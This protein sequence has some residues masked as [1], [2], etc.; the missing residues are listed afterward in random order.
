MFKLSSPFLPTGDQPQAI[1][2]LVKNLMSGARHQ[3][4]LGV[5]GSGKTFTMANVIAQTQRPTLV[6]SPNK[7]L[8][9]QLWQE[10]RE[11]FPENPV[12]Y[13][14]SYYDY[15]QP[16]AYLPAT[17]TY[18]EKDAKINDFIDRLRHATTQ[19]ALSRKDFI[20]VASVS[21]IYGIGNP[22]EYRKMSL[23]LR[24][25]ET[26]KRSILLRRLAMLQYERLQPTEAPRQGTYRVNGD[27]MMLLTPDGETSMTIELLGD[28]V[29]RLSARKVYRPGAHP[30][31][32]QSVR[33]FPAKHFVAPE[34]SLA[35]AI[36]NIEA[37]LEGRLAALKKEGKIF[38]AARLQERTRFDLTMLR[39]TGYCNGIENYSRH[40]ASRAPGEA[41][42]TLLDYLPKHT[43]VFS[44]QMKMCLL[45]T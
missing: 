18:I 17:D 7:T 14:V 5:T 3:T 9:A 43:L 27:H 24:A 1:A 11:F 21:C 29:E 40:L 41:P 38:E 31:E 28:T 16:E 32:M 25:G 22:E 10:F 26:C 20:I 45:T 13:F 6:I 36:A 23:E 8:A 4:L 44:E 39:E 37:E 34:S 19:T 42:H 12:H 2:A 33:I 35:P 15:Y 30:V